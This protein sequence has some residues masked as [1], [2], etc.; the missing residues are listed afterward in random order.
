MFNTGA[1]ILFTPFHFKNGDPSKD[2]FFLVLRSV[3]NSVVLASLPT[4]VNQAPSLI[5][6][7]HGCVNHDER[8]FNCYVY[9]PN[10][11]ICDSNFSFSVPTFIYPNNVEDFDVATLQQKYPVE[12]ADYQIMGNLLPQELQELLNCI[13][14][15]KGGVKRKIQRML[16]A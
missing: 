2:K 8:M 10:R 6:T 9:E 16:F 5:N 11:I 1:L 15:S 4:K 14:K 7:T 12:G 13:E 3:G